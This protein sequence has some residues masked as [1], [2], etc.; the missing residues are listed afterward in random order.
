MEN[1]GKGILPIFFGFFVVFVCSLLLGVYM[2]RMLVEGGR[3][4]AGSYV[5]MQS[6][7][8][9]QELAQEEAPTPSPMDIPKESLTI[10]PS[11]E[12]APLS[13]AEVSETPLPEG[14]PSS[15]PL[16]EEA[17]SPTPQPPKSSKQ[18]ASLPSAD[19]G[20][21]YTVQVGSF[22]SEDAA[23]RL[24]RMLKSNGYPAFVKK[25]TVAGKGT[26]YR[27]RVGTFKTREEALSYGEALKSSEPRV[28]AT[29]VTVNN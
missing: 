18:V 24:E 14:T 1:R 4:E 16:A 25:S 23:V 28:K 11:E 7:T 27:V 8:E 5:E 3:E 6:T 2:G 15:A 13:E 9:K 12:E 21:I 10:E 19:E 26:W 29:L 22:N 17:P 20:G